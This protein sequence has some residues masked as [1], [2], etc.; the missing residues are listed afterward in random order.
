MTDYVP[1]TVKKALVGKGHA[2]KDQVSLMVR[3]L[4]GG[5]NLETSDETDALA[6]AICHAHHGGLK[7]HAGQSEI[8]FGVAL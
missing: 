4:L 8:G 1:N 2:D 7:N 6:L 3:H 5:I